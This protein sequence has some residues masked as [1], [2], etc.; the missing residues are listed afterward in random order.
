MN[1]REKLLEQYE[2]AYFALLM[3]EVAEQEGTRL[4]K[5]NKEL[6]N[7]PKAAVPDEVDRKC[8][9]AIDRH[10]IRQRRGKFGEIEID[11]HFF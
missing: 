4:E 7:D 8:I 6:Q 2:D 10:F 9:K 5:L 1:R 11:G 3:D